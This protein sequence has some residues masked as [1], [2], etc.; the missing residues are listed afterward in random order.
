M[1]DELALG[2]EILPVMEGAGAASIFGMKG[3]S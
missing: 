2:G 3:G 1:L